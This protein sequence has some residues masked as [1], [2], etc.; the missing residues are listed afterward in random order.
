MSNKLNLIGRKFGRLTVVKLRKDCSSIIREDKKKVFRCSR[1]DCICECGN[2]K[3]DVSKDALYDGS[4]KSCGCLNAQNIAESRKIRINGK[5]G[6]PP[7]AFSKGQGNFHRV[8]HGIKER[9]YIK[10]DTSFHNYGGRGITMFTEW[11]HSYKAFALYIGPRP[12]RQHSVDRI[13]NNV[14]YYPGNV[15]W[16]TNKEQSN[17]KR[18]NVWV[19]WKGESMTLMQ[20]SEY[21]LINYNV[22]HKEIRKHRDVD[23]VEIVAK[24]KKSKQAFDP[25]KRQRSKRITTN[26]PTPDWI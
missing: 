11:R 25:R 9:C 7:F 26:H 22:L 14:G 5:D 1:W 6:V 3:N 16:V 12:S 13:D 4:T 19:N 17:N 24:C 2:L 15:R 20:L 10:S 18:T 23:I 21:E 8:W